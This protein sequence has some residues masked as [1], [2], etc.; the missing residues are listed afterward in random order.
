MAFNAIETHVL[1][2]IG[3]NTSSPDVFTDTDVGIE[4]IRDSISDAIE[5][6]SMLTGSYKAVYRLPLI[7]SQGFYRV[8]LTNGSIGWITDVW[9][10]N[11][12]FRMTQTDENKLSSENPRWMVNSGNPRQYFQIGKDVIGVYP[13][14]SSTSDLVEVTM[15]VIPKEYTSGTDRLFLRDAFKWGAVH[16][17]VSEYYASRGD[18]R[19]A[20]EHH[21]KYLDHVGLQSL[22]QKSAER[23]PFYKTAK[24]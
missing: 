24:Q 20:T 5:E 4:P 3:E 12:K 11:Q 19:S 22:Y 21:K 9:L 7:E 15:V 14:P 8:T 18:A 16:Y 6:I 10:V 2:M 17:A 1:E 13:R 23:I